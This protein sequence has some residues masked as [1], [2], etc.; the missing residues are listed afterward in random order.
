VWRLGE[1]PPLG[2]PVER[3]AGYRTEDGDLRAVAMVRG[4]GTRH[5]LSGSSAGW[6]PVDPPA[7]MS[8][9][10]FAPRPGTHSV[11]VVGSLGGGAAAASVDLAPDASGG[12]DVASG[13]EGGDI[14]AAGLGLIDAVGKS[15]RPGPIGAAGTAGNTG[16]ESAG[17]GG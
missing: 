12:T 3:I 10:D 14:Q 9:T 6:T 8:V 16:S 1:L 11:W 13:G 2:Q 7:G 15:F 4:G 17:D 5:L